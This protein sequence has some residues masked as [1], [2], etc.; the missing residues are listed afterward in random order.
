MIVPEVVLDISV[1]V[2]E[3][4]PDIVIVQVAAMSPVIQAGLSSGQLV[5]RDSG[6][7]SPCLDLG[8]INSSLVEDMTA[9]G[10]DL[11]VLEGMGR[12]IHTNLYIKFRYL[13]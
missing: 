2:P 7:G 3:V 10:V 13:P 8:K 5:T 11:L 9:R 6:Q 1:T 4:V 12:A